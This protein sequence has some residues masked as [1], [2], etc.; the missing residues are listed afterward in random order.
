MSIFHVTN[1]YVACVFLKVTVRNDL[2]VFKSYHAIA[3]ESKKKNHA[4]AINIK[5]DSH[6]REIF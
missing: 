1:K 6:K 3:I 4:I 2:N 5:F